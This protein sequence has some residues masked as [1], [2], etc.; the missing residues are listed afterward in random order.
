[1]KQVPM[2]KDWYPQ[3]VVVGKNE[4]HELAFQLNPQTDLKSLELR[5]N[6]DV[7]RQALWDMTHNGVTLSKEVVAGEETTTASHKS[8]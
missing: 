4:A 2:P 6:V 5:K 7:L 8:Q 1:M 3:L